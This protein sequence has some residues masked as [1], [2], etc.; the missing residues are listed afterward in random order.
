MDK[1][2]NNFMGWAFNEVVKD[3]SPPP[4][5]T[6]EEWAAM[7]S[8]PSDIGDG[9]EY[10]EWC[11]ENRPPNAGG[12]PKSPDSSSSA[13]DD[14]SSKDED[15]DAEEEAEFDEFGDGEE[16][17]AWH[18][19]SEAFGTPSASRSTSP[20][21]KRDASHFSPQKGLAPPKKRR[22]TPRSKPLNKKREDELTSTIFNLPSDL[23]AIRSA[24]FSLHA[25][26]RVVI[27]TAAEWKQIWPFVDNIWVRNMERKMTKKFTQVSYWYC[28]LY[29]GA[30]DTKGTGQRAKK[31]RTSPPC[32]MKLKMMKRFNPNDTN[33]L[34]SV[35]LLLHTEE[36]D[37]WSIHNH[38]LDFADTVKINSYIMDAAG[39]QVALGYEPAHIHRVLIGVKWTG[40]LD[41]LKAA[42]GSHFTL[43]DVHNAGIEWR[44]AH[45]DLRHRGSRV[46]WEQ[47]Q[48]ELL[49]AL[50]DREGILSSNVEAV[51]NTDGKM[52]YAT[53]FASKSKSK[54]WER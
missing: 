28:R 40:N 26:Q 22:S 54:W 42:G 20:A 24:V 29:R 17:E 36:K 19:V 16:D 43:K 3:E 37:P 30:L 41:A 6:A 39:Q 48:Q 1:A 2:D 18:T 5:P 45:P 34:E 33:Q 44:R 31:M 46:P 47:Q 21:P 51:R 53:A 15:E 4:P 32:G 9:L 10:R 8:T 13:A 50:K 52:T 14:V 25:G 23:P 7:P 27:W 35:T 49:D 11:W 12:R 38:S